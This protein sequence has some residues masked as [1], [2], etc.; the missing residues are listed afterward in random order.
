ML[1]KKSGSD[2]LYIIT[3]LLCLLTMYVHFSDSI[4]SDYFI[5]YSGHSI[6]SS[7]E[8][9]EPQDEILWQI[10]VDLDQNSLSVYKNGMLEKTY[11]CSGGKNETPSPT[12]DFMIISKE[13]WG[14]GFGGVWMGLSVP[15]GTFGIHGTRQP[16]VIGKKNVS[17]GC[18]RMLT[19]DAKELAD[20]VPLQTPVRIQ[21]KN[22]PFFT[23]YTGDT[24]SEIWNSQVILN[25]LGYYNGEFDGKFGEKTKEAI[26]EF[27]SD[28]G[29]KETGSLNKDTYDTILKMRNNTD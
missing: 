4:L 8:E 3:I 25:K 21:Q 23:L 1:D 28:Y 10:V 12:G 14:E 20:M 26:L 29:L 18:I 11:P 22:R 19:A 15:W 2:F 9:D 5:H 7:F 6:H 24:G 27:Q 17:K 16:W 13:T